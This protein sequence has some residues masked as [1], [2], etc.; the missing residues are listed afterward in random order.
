VHLG[1]MSSTAL[2]RPGPETS[3]VWLHALNGVLLL[4]LWVF[5]IA[6]Y[7]G[8][9]ELVPG[10]IGV[11]G[12]TRWDAKQNSPWFIMPI[13]AFVNAALM[14][15]AS[16]VSKSTPDGFNVPAKKQLMQ[17][18]RAGQLHALAPMRGFMYGLAT[19]L[20]VLSLY[21]QYQLYRIA[22]A[23]PDS[24]TGTGNLLAFT[25]V[26][27]AAVLLM[28]FLSTRMVKRR[29]AEWQSMDEAAGGQA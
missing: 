4:A 17:L 19:W 24:E 20:L 26:M 27:L 28:A 12:V 14:Y 21:I 1:G 22:H 15:G 25:A 10:H 29:I 7:P 3:Y 2:R 11:G 13:L 6:A 18:P 9:P 5:T 16:A 8:L 23:G